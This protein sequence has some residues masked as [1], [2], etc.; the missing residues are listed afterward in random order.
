MAR[1]IIARQSGQRVAASEVVRGSFGQRVRGVVDPAR[2]T[3]NSFGALEAEALRQE[4]EQMGQRGQLIA[5]AF[6]RVAETS[7]AIRNRQR[8]LRTLDERQEIQQIEDDVQLEVERKFLEWDKEARS[9]KRVTGD[10]YIA[11]RRQIIEETFAKHSPRAADFKSDAARNYDKRVAAKLRQAQERVGFDGRT[12][13]FIMERG[14]ARVASQSESVINSGIAGRIGQDAAASYQV[15]LSTHQRLVSLYGDAANTVLLGGITIA[16]SIRD[17]QVNLNWSNHINETIERANVLPWQSGDA[18]IEA[19]GVQLKATDEEGNFLLFP[20]LSPKGRSDAISSLEDERSQ[21]KSA[22]VIDWKDRAGK[23]STTFSLGGRADIDSLEQEA[24]A[25][26][27]NGKKGLGRIVS[28]LRIERQIASKVKRERQKP[29]DQIVE[30]IKDQKQAAARRFSDS[31]AQLKILEASEK[32]ARDQ[33]LAIKNN[34]YLSYG[35]ESYNVLLEEMTADG[36]LPNPAN[37]AKAVTRLQSIYGEE[38]IMWYT[39]PELKILQATMSSMVKNGNEA[40]FRNYIAKTLASD[41]IAHIQDDDRIRR[42]VKKVIDFLSSPGGDLKTAYMMRQLE[43]AQKQT[44]ASEQANANI[45]KAF[46][47]KAGEE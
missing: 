20:G 11:R 21:I 3:A 16:D 9:D 10:E 37:R 27:P 32:A 36:Q 45:S 6:D 2:V 26:D 33:K 22:A 12:E 14:Q 31:P 5:G 34:D 7:L 17:K 35:A 42:E 4:A 25:L 15:S 13:K 40:E 41:M 39:G 38:H 1:F 23:A 24:K 28:D 43:E 30:S 47:N 19:L 44:S 18:E 29:L 46:A 8:A